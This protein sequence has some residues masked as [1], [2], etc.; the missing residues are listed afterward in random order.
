MR[1][2]ILFFLFLFLC[3]ISSAQRV[4]MR[5]VTLR[6]EN[7]SAVSD[8]GMLT[9]EIDVRMADCI[10]YIEINDV[11]KIKKVKSTRDKLHD[12]WW[13]K[14]RQIYDFKSA[15][16][17]TKEIH[18][19]DYFLK[20]LGD[21]EE[22]ISMKCDLLQMKSVFGRKTIRKRL[23][24]NIYSLSGKKIYSKTIVLDK[25]ELI[26]EEEIIL[27]RGSSEINK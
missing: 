16:T 25:N 11:D 22:H 14:V 12:W 10:D 2:T 1:K 24:I 20:D 9:F 7:Y 27:K 8:D 19:S 15:R 18:E 3:K 13:F 21:D 17:F 4:G 23:E 5:P 6:L 26:E